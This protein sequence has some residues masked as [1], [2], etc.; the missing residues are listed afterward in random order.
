M[1]EQET[2][3]RMNAW[4]T[5]TAWVMAVVLSF[6]AGACREKEGNVGRFEY[7]STG[8]LSAELTRMV[9][10]EGAMSGASDKEGA[11]G[12]IH[13]RIPKK[14]GLKRIKSVAP[15]AFR[16]C[17]NVASV[18]IPPKVST[19]GPEAFAEC[20]DL[21]WVELP[22]GLTRV[23]DG[24]FRDCRRMTESVIPDRVE[25][26]GE[27]A[28]RGCV[29]LG[30]VELPE[31]LR[32]VGEHAFSGCVS[33]GNLELPSGT[34]TLE[35]YAF[36]GCKSLKTFVLP[37][38]LTKIKEGLFADCT[39]LEKIEMPADVRKLGSWA[40][41][42]CTS[43]TS[44]V[45]PEGLERIGRGVFAD[46]RALE[47]V[48]LPPDVAN[49]PDGAFEGCR[50]LRSV[51]MPEGVTNI[52]ARAFA[53]CV[54]LEDIEWPAGL[55]TVGEGAF[56]GCTALARVALPE[57]VESLGDRVFAECEGVKS[58]GFPAGLTTM[59]NAVFAGC[60]SLW[61]LVLPGSVER[62]G[63]DLVAGCDRLLM[64][65]VPD[66]LVPE[67]K[68][69]AAVL[70]DCTICPRSGWEEARHGKWVETAPDPFYGFY[71][72]K[73]LDVVS[74]EGTVLAASAVPDP[75]R[76]DYDDCLCALLVE[77]DSLLSPP[78]ADQ[79]VERVVLVNVPIMKDRTI[80]QRNVFEPGARISCWCAAYDA[81]PQAIREIQLSDDIQTFEYQQ[82][83]PLKIDSVSKFRKTGNKN[84]AKREITILPVRSLPRDAHAAAARRERIRSEIALI[85][86]ELARH[87]GS[88]EAWKE[89]YKPIAEKYERLCGEGHAGWINDSY[90]AAGGAETTYMTQ[91]YIEGLLPY[92]KH[93]EKNNIDLIVVRMPSRWDFAARVLASENFQ[94]N[95]AW[96][97]HYYECLK[98][99]IEIIDPM[100]EM[101]KER[102]DFPLFYFYH[103]PD[104]FHPCEGA[105]FIVAK[106]TAKVLERYPFQK[107]EPE[108]T[109]RDFRFETGRDIY[110]W[111]EGNEKFDPSKNLVFKQALQ[112]DEPLG[113]VLDSGSPF[114]F[115]SGSL[116]WF[117]QGDLG[118]SVPGYAA[119]F[120]QARTDWFYQRGDFNP[121]IKH[122]ANSQIL[123][124]RRAVVMV[125][126]PENWTTVPPM[127]R[128]I[129]DGVRRIAL[130][131]TIPATSDEIT[132]D[133]KD[134]FSCSTS[135]DGEIHF[136][137]NGKP[138]E[139][140]ADHFDIRFEIPYV[141]G[142]QAC[143]VRVNTGR[144]SHLLVHLVDDGSDA[145]LDTNSFLP[146]QRHSADFF[147]PLSDPG[148]S[149]TIRFQP[150]NEYGLSI[151]NIEL[152]YY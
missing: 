38:R 31:G 66:N 147:V 92:K 63:K 93:L 61:E 151:K 53:G 48:E 81:M 111:P 40:F 29:Q 5:M 102:F 109:L 116:F 84:F 110:L 136:V 52:G 123:D 152:W 25:E 114:L 33:L 6:G 71:T 105:A 8:W 104:E 124:S 47:H 23:E 50:G 129:L 143:M 148:T 41:K 18:K 69:E 36:S 103:C 125:G 85:E 34:E 75:A 20:R 126:G 98:N 10:E 59:G 78:P 79:N 32:S 146:G 138:P 60:R 43:L 2:P 144:I 113:V 13:L 9:E 62:V 65:V 118:A 56:E 112:G 67:A 120:L 139:Q 119:Y 37:P 133:C 3:S 45:L 97:E 58:V 88:F 141:E 26:I 101:W 1:G 39:G 7:C 135:E 54:M 134:A 46:C 68:R 150:K 127:P 106:E 82:Y 83:Y 107:A 4:K 149:V 87:G 128:Y 44:V 28:Y 55:R 117:P 130:E 16:Q 12:P 21:V 122:L 73:E 19:I 57:S 145:I 100:P 99:D 108:I 42:G 27:S 94:E 96:V 80:V 137:P 49:I 14:L 30:R 91:E 17:R 22:S 115:F 76:N 140:R 64:L 51:R 131:K 15:G 70:P 77:L 95:P 89:E 35:S 11:Q 121:R 24:L 142:K 90:F 132:V 72:G 86:S 74:F